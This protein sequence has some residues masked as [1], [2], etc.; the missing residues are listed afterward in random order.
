MELIHRYA[1]KLARLITND[2]RKQVYKYNPITEISVTVVSNLDKP[3]IKK[4]VKEG[5][6]YWSYLC[7]VPKAPY[8]NEF[9]DH[10]AINMRM[11]P[12]LAWDYHI[13]GILMW[14]TNHWYSPVASPHGYLQNPW[15]DPMSY[16]ESYGTAYGQIKYWGNGDGRYL[17]PLNPNPFKNNKVD[18]RAPV[19]SIRLEYLREGIEDYDY[20]WLLKQD[21]KNAKPN[22]NELI[23]RAKDL[24]AIPS[25]I[26]QSGD[27]YTKNPQLLASYRN[28]LAKLLVKFNR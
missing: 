23:G 18:M 26:I 6:R 14:E 1:P 15:K 24:L 5:Q 3:K 28:K 11:W 17:Y 4:S 27:K 25:N 2:N 8:V 22:Q 20:F 9:I 12:W 21:I 13:T 16:V 7:T 19:L 10:K